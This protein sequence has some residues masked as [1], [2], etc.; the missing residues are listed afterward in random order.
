MSCAERYARPERLREKLGP[1]AGEVVYPPGAVVEVTIPWREALWVLDYLDT[2]RE[3]GRWPWS[4]ERP[5]REARHAATGFMI[6][7]AAQRDRPDGVTFEIWPVGYDVWERAL[8]RAGLD[9]EADR[10][11]AKIDWR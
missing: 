1:V 3:G 4:R 2:L 8:R 6:E 9:G 5:H 11:A 7:A 10:V